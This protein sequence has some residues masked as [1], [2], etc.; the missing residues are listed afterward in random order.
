MSN[1]APLPFAWGVLYAPPNHD[2]S[3]KKCANCAFW[4]RDHERCVI[5]K[6][7][8]IVSQGMVCGYHVEGSLSEKHPFNFVT[9]LDPSLSG[10]MNTRDLDGTSCGTCKFFEYTERDKGLC[11]GVADKKTHEPP[12]QVQVMGCCARW[13]RLE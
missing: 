10:L 8:L 7:D 1:K 9:P 12:A 13:E 6:R 2:G 11:H 5:H 4:V 3:A